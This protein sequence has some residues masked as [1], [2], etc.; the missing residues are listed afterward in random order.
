MTLDELKAYDTLQRSIEAR[1]N[2]LIRMRS[3]AEQ[4]T[5]L[6]SLAPAHSGEADKLAAQVAEIVDFETEVTAA[7]LDAERR[8]DQI[9]RWLLSLPEQQERVMR[10]KYVERAKWG[11]VAKRTGYVVRHCKRIHKAVLE[12]MSLNVTP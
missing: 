2:T 4:T 5:Q 3:L 7:K 8:L 11:E 10:A 6:L 1:E 9:E 12:K